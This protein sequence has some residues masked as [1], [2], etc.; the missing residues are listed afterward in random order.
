[1]VT[2]KEKTKNVKGGVLVISE[3]QYEQ[4]R[5]AF[6]IGLGLKYHNLKPDD[7]FKKEMNPR[8]LRMFDVLGGVARQKEFKKRKGFVLSP[9]EVRELK[10]KGRTEFCSF[11]IRKTKGGCVINLGTMRLRGKIR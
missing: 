7:L 9:Y 11:E 10:E 6:A 4:M 3:R 2:M 5:V 8:W 1:M